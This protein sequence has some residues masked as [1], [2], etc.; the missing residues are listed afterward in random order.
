[1]SIA[2]K[3]KP[4]LAP[5]PVDVEALIRRGGSTPARRPAVADSPVIL[6]VPAAILARVDEA[7]ARR[8]LRTPRHRW[9]L[10][11][12]QEKLEREAAEPARRS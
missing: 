9:L 10:E 5:G 8:P 2:R 12:I 1:M 3:P 6:R 4:P 11:A 7:V